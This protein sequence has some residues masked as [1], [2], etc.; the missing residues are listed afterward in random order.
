M[1]F[2]TPHNASHPFQEKEPEA[3][4]EPGA[5]VGCALV[6]SGLT[7]G[8]DHCK[9]PVVPVQIKSKKNNN[10]MVNYAFLDQGSTDVFCTV[11]LINKLKLSGKRTRNLLQTIG[12]EKVMNI[13][14]VKGLKVAGLDGEVYCDLPNAYTKE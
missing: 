5:A 10:T 3:E 4:G 2:E 11:N 7:G 6:S 1:Q 14:V 13:Y 9:L 8:G 12:Q